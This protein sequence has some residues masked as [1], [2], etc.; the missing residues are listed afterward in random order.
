MTVLQL[1]ERLKRL[2][3]DANIELKIEERLG[4]AP[5]GPFD[6]GDLIVLEGDLSDIDCVFESGDIWTVTLRSKHNHA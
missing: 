4:F 5:W 2:P 1:I 3:E 6:I